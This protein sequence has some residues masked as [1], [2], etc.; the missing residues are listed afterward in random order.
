MS[1]HANDFPDWLGPMIVK[2]LRQGLKARAFALSFVA[3]QIVLVVVVAYHALLYERSPKGFDGTGLNA[4]FWVLL[5]V[6]LLIVTPGRALNA[7]AAERRANTLELV[8]MSGLS[9]WRIAVGKWA[10][11]LC[12]A[13]LFVVAILPYAIL[14]YFFGSVNLTEDW[15]FLGVMLLLSATLSAAALAV[16]GA[17]PFVRMAVLVFGGL[18]VFSAF[19]ALLFGMAWGRSGG[20]FV[21][22]GFIFE[23]VALLEIYDAILLTVLFLEI[24][25][26]SIAPLAENHTLRHRVI[27]L[28][29]L[30]PAPALF[31]AGAAIP[32]HLAQLGLFLLIGLASCAYELS[33]EPRFLRNQ[34]RPFAARGRLAALVGRAFYPGWPS[35]LTLLLFV[36]FAA[37]AIGLATFGIPRMPLK[38][39][40]TDCV[41]GVAGVLMVGAAVLTPRLVLWWRRSRWPLFEHGLVHLF[42]VALAVFVNAMLQFSAGK[43]GDQF[44]LALYPPAGI[45][46]LISS[47]SGDLWWLLLGGGVFVG[48]LSALLIRARRHWRQLRQIERELRTP[49]ALP[50]MQPAEA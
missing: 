8:F 11:L 19:P 12:Q 33:R 25:A 18:F 36:E 31:Y 2:E 22:G 20:I 24:A 47:D 45:W 3:L 7:L 32:I 9:A 44:W 35:A 49:L 43:L 15:L 39:S 16:S 37:I 27:A 28:S 46:A 10:S 50:A 6:Q 23:P 34:I 14:R 29:V 48:F 21:H 5:S 38:G 13:V 17:P 26:T 41:K 42:G 1:T 40:A 30:L 4:I